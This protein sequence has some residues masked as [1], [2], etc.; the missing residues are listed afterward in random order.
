MEGDSKRECK[1]CLKRFKSEDNVKRHIKSVHHLENSLKC[2]D[3]GKNFTRQD[4]LTLPL[5]DIFFVSKFAL[6]LEYDRA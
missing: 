2:D 5:P 1:Y 3:C 4:S 6:S